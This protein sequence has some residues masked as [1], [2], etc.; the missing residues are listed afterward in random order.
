MKLSVLKIF[1][2]AVVFLFCFATVSQAAETIQLEKSVKSKSPTRSKKVVTPQPPP[3]PGPNN[4]QVAPGIQQQLPKKA[5]IKKILGKIY[6]KSPKQGDY[7]TQGDQ[8]TIRWDRV[9]NVKADCFQLFLF[10]GLSMVGTITNQWAYPNFQWTVPANQSGSSYKIR[11]RTCDNQYHA[12][13]ATF[14]IISAKPDLSVAKHSVVSVENIAGGDRD[15]RFKARIDNVGHAQSVVSTARVVFTPTAAAQGVSREITIPSMPF[16]GHHYINEPISLYAPGQWNYTITLIVPNPPQN[17]P[18]TGNNQASGSYTVG[19]YADLHML[20]I[21][22]DP[23][24]KRP[25]NR[26]V[27]ISGPVRNDGNQA[28]QNFKIT[29]SCTKCNMGLASGSSH[30]EK[31]KTI[32]NLW[33]GATYWWDFNL[34]WP[35]VGDMTCRVRADSENTVQEFRENNNTQTTE[36]KVVLI[37]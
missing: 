17:D 14:P 36:V 20:S 27:R 29:I 24:G 15:I 13:S 2:G 8:V 12:D 23:S 26:S 22:K 1:A 11:L 16:A 7:F 18:N 5:V 28:A 30:M 6:F 9:G 4:H 10:K 32:A 37:K 33:P 34:S 31:S 21:F 3:P 19:S 25:I 35:C